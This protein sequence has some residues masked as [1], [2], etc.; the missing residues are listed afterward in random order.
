VHLTFA[1][2]QFPLVRFPGLVGR[3][4]WLDRHL[5]GRIRRAPALPLVGTSLAVAI[6]TA[7]AASSALLVAVARAGQC[8]LCRAGAL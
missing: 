4:G 2:A 3:D 1:G 5:P 7:T 6:A 8:A